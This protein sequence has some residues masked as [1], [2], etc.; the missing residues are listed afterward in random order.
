MM[1]EIEVMVI[2]KFNKNQI[3]I[4]INNKILCQVLLKEVNQLIPMESKKFLLISLRKLKIMEEKLIKLDR[5]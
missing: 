2:E 3:L 4:R 5:K 1:L